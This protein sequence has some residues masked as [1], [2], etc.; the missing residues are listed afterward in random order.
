MKAL[1]YIYTSWE[2]GGSQTKGY[3]IYSKS[4]GISDDE[5][6]DIRRIMQYRPPMNLVPNPTPEQIVDEFPY[7]FAY[8]AL[9][10][11]RRCIALSTYLGKD[12]SNRYG[13]YI[14]YALVFEMDELETYPAEFFGE[15]FLKTYM[16]VE[17]LKAESP[18]P[19]LPV[20]EIDSVGDMINEDMIIDFA[21]DHEEQVIKF[22]D[23]LIEARKTKVP[24]FI[25]D[26]RENLAMW[27]AIA[28]ELF[29]LEIAKNMYFTTY[30]FDQN[31]VMKC[32]S[33]YDK[34]MSIIGVWPSGNGFNY[35]S[36]MHNAD[37]VVIDFVNGYYTEGIS[38]NV[39]SVELAA[40]MT[41]GMSEIREFGQYLEKI[42]AS[43]EMPLN[44]AYLYYKLLRYGS[45]DYS[46]CRLGDI[47][48]FAEKYEDQEEN[49]KVASNLLDT[50]S[51]GEYPSDTGESAALLSYLYKNIDF[52]MFSIHELFIRI[53]QNLAAGSRDEAMRFYEIIKQRSPMAVKSLEEYFVSFDMINYNSNYLVQHKDHDANLFYGEILLDILSDRGIE[54]EAERCIPLIHTIV[55]NLA[56]VNS[57]END[58]SVLFS[59]A[60]N[61]PEI[62]KALVSDYNSILEPSKKSGFYS[63]F[64]QTLISQDSGDAEKT[65]MTLMS[66]SKTAD[67][68]VYVYS[69]VINDP[70]DG[71]KFFWDFIDRLKQRGAAGGVD[72]STLVEAYLNSDKKSS[73]GCGIIERVD[74]HWI[75]SAEIRKKVILRTEAASVKEL[76]GL[77]YMVIDKAHILSANEGLSDK[78]PNISAIMAGRRALGDDVKVYRNYTEMVQGIEFGLVHMDPKNYELFLTEY[79]EPLLALVSSINEMGE[80]IE[81]LYNEQRFPLFV[82]MLSSTLKKVQKKSPDKWMDY[83]SYTSIWVINNVQRNSVT[84]KFQPYFIQYL[85]KQDDKDI[86]EL[87]VRVR[88]NVGSG[89]EIRFFDDVQKKERFKDKVGNAFKR[90]I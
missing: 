52:M 5:C 87:E 76:K 17:E 83:L 78:I 73:V 75:L 40:D 77:K 66:D 9:G 19:P 68:C 30:A 34:Q 26:T 48:D 54:G 46:N 7:G 88:R 27:C 37:K 18:V 16:T 47:L 74:F 10:S 79:L 15:E 70:Q 51:N 32:M 12:Y 43:E 21:S 3:M 90:K 44:A 39:A 6:E 56:K 71:G 20:L 1:Q 8:F 55:R 35:A 84:E 36:E 31:N 85:K 82:N 59:K 4:V 62:L 61:I 89:K 29:P 22:I 11:G 2:N 69:T 80:L 33:E 86:E 23:A 41:L 28:Q 81:D 13:N 65:F 25:N 58:C 53:L 60:I 38:G 64:L 63:A 57:I 42:G 72:I 49:Q 67:V 45:Y 14:I 24:I 50:F